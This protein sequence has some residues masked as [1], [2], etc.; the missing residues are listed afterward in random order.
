MWSRF[1]MLLKGVTLSI[2]LWYVNISAPLVKSYGVFLTRIICKTYGIL[3]QALVRPSYQAA[4]FGD[5]VSN[6]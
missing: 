6:S 5:E 4:A 2:L 3:L 1:Y